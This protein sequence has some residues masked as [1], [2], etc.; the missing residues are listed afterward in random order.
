MR[1]I[2]TFLLGVLFGAGALFLLLRAVPDEPAP[3]VAAPPPAGSPGVPAAQIEGK[4]PDAPLVEADLSTLDL[5]LR[6]SQDLPPAHRPT[7]P[8]PQ[9]ARARCWFRY[10]ASKWPP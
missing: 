3:S 10:K 4:L 6:P 5:P 2:M 1:S 8:Q 9:P 7:S